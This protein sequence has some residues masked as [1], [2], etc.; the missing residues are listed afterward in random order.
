MYQKRPSE[1]IKIEDDYVAYCL[2]EAISEFIIRIENEETPRFID[3]NTK[4]DN[5]GLKL[6]M[7]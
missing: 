1:I 7:K 6:L 3:N 2:D 4:K 5:P